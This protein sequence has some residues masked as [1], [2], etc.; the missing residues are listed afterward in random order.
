MSKQHRHTFEDWVEAAQEYAEEHLDLWPFQ[1]K[2]MASDFAWRMEGCK[3]TKKAVQH[4]YDDWISGNNPYS[5]HTIQLDGYDRMGQWEHDTKMAARKMVKIGVQE[6]LETW[7]AERMVDDIVKQHGH[8]VG[9]YKSGK[10]YR[11]WMDEW[12]NGT[13][14]FSPYHVGL[15]EVNLEERKARQQEIEDRYAG[16]SSLTVMLESYMADLR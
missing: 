3:I 11:Q 10:Y 1:V 14:R 4:A 6:G 15:D 9:I 2:E 13:N 16:R 12:K 7:Q 8:S 5:I